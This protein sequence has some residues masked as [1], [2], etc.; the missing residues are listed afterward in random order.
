MCL[1]RRVLVCEYNNRLWNGTVRFSSSNACFL[2]LKLLTLY[3]SYLLDYKINGQLHVYWIV[4][5]VTYPCDISWCFHISLIPGFCWGRGKGY[6]TTD[7]LGWKKPLESV[8]FQVLLQCVIVVIA[9]RTICPLSL[10]LSLTSSKGE[11][12]LLSKVSEQWKAPSSLPVF[13]CPQVAL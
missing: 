9:L 4:P 6:V 10:F 11:G 12:T 5:C 8:S 1:A 2:T 13:P 7:K 3:K